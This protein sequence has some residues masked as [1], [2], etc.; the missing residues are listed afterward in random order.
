MK[1]IIEILKQYLEENELDFEEVDL[2][3]K[4][5][6]EIKSDFILFSNFFIKYFN[7]FYKTFKGYKEAEK[8]IGLNKNHFLEI[9]KLNTQYNNC[10]SNVVK[11]N[12]KSHLVDY[13]KENYL[14]LNEFIDVCVGVAE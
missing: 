9:L 5:L 10:S 13:I 14:E 11:Y 12:K 4:T 7:N 2:G 1:K 3:D 6:D 8:F